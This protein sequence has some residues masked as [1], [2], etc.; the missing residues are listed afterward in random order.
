MLFLVIMA[1]CGND[2]TTTK[3]TKKETKSAQTETKTA[4]IE[5]E[6]EPAAEETNDSEQ[7]ADI[8]GLGH[9]KTLGVGYN[10][11]AG[12]DGTKADAKPIEMGSMQLT[13]NGIA[14]VEVEPQEDVK[15]MF[16]NADKVRAVVVDLI[17]ENTAEED[18]TFNPNQAILVTDT[19]EQVEAEMGMM[20]D[21]GGDFLGK[22]KKE[23]QSWWLLKN[24]DKDIKKITMIV[25]PPYTTADWSE[26]AKEKRIEFEILPWEEALKKDGKK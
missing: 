3:E 8:D 20:G 1:A 21:A 4:D 24:V 11:E 17:A 2:T 5:K 23:G 7:E 26:T 14:V 15:V 10:D 16:N 12:L 19:G 18:I 22:V 6:S 25:S 13:I 9:I